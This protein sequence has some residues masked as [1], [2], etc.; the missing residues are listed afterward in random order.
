LNLISQAKIDAYEKQKELIVDAARKYVLQNGNDITWSGDTATI[1]LSDLQNANILDNPLKNPKGGNFDNTSNGTKVTIT[2]SGN[3]YTYVISGTEVVP[4]YT[5][6]KGVNRPKLITGMT[7]IKWS[8]A[9]W[10]DTTESDPDWYN[11]TTTDKKWANAR[12]KDNSMWVWI[13]RYAYQIETNYHLNTKGTINIKFLKN[14]T[15]IASDGSTVDTAPTYNV[16]SQTNFI[17]HPAFTFGTT[18]VT[19]IWVAKF[20]A[21]VSDINDLCYTSESTANCNK[22]TIIPKIVPDVKS[23]RYITIGNMFTVSRSMETNNTYGWGTDGIGLDTHMMKNIEWGAVVYLSQSTYGKNSEVWINNSSTYTTGCAG[24]NVSA[25][26]YAGCQY[27]YNTPDNGLNAS[28]TG[29]ISGIYDMSG[30]TREYTAAYVQNGN[31]ATNGNSIVTADS[32]YKDVYT[33]TTDSQANNYNN[34]ISK[35]GDAVYET[36]SSHLGYIA[37]YSDYVEMPYSTLPWF[38]R[39]STCGDGAAAGL[40]WFYSVDGIA[41]AFSGF[42]PIVLVGSGL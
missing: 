19:G 4:D 22:T 26:S 20:E 8:G 23:W 27:A 14:D 42:R 12:T 32:K 36:S 2:R 35:K 7:P 38:A 15:K 31:A 13:P 24:L 16:N 5:V 9:A 40:F 3:Q 10:V 39:G 37:W 30:G 11:Y 18:E 21:S 1:Y 28:T 41:E 34:A 25:S 6:S 33:I 17:L 29:N